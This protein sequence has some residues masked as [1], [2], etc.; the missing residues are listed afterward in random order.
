MGNNEQQQVR[1]LLAQ[2]NDARANNEMPLGIDIIEQMR[3]KNGGYP[4]FVY[5]AGQQAVAVNNKQQEDGLAALGYQR[6]YR[7]QA[8]PT[9]L[10]R[11]NHA[12]FRQR[13]L[14]SKEFEDVP[15]FPDFVETT[16]AR[17]EQ[18][19]ESLMMQRV[20]KDCSPWCKNMA[21]LP[22]ADE[23]PGESPEA[24]IAR[25]RGQIEA[26]QAGGDSLPVPDGALSKRE[27]RAR[28]QQ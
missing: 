21:D 17:D 1:D 4:R 11:R 27:R 28:S 12:T 13:I 20:P 2:F 3:G 24:T 25:L 10:Y 5:K 9:T 22:A 18:H 26:L 6:T 19:E 7:H 16:I 23:G 15:K 8:Y 14:D